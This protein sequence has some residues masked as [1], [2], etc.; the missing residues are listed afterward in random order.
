MKNLG[1]EQ[2]LSSKNCHSLKILDLSW[3]TFTGDIFKYLTNSKQL[4]EL[5]ELEV[6]GLKNIETELT[7]YLNSNNVNSLTKLDISSTSIG[8]ETARIIG[9]SEALECLN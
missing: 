4:S 2:L 9:N 3:N 8:E 1:L 5:K 6:S 7:Y